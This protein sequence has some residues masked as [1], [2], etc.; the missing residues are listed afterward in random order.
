MAVSVEHIRDFLLPGLRGIVSQYKDFPAYWEMAVEQTVA[1]PHIWVPKL[2]LPAAVAV[3][4][5]ALIVKNPIVT[6]RF[7][8]GWTPIRA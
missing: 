6:R 1:A 4:T 7:W 2:S 5:A 3:G 8:Q